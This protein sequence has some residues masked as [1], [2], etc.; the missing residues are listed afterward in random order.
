MPSRE[1]KSELWNRT[2]QIT[3]KYFA[4]DSLEYD[5]EI[6]HTPFKKIHPP[7]LIKGFRGW[8]S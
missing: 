4:Y 7:L 3:L 6:T 1:A 8:I 5:F 2:T